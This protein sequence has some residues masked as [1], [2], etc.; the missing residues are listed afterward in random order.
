[1][2]V[3]PVP[4][5]DS[6]RAPETAR[7]GPRPLARSTGT[8]LWAQLRADLLRRLEGGEFREVFPGE[9]DLVAEYRVSRHTVREALRQLRAQGLVTAQ[10]GRPSRLTAARPLEQKVGEPYS[11]F[12]SVEEVGAVQRSVVHALDQRADGVVAARLGLEESTPLVYLER[13]RLADE[14]PLAVDRVWLPAAVARPLLDVDLTRT[15]LY[16]ELERHCA[17]RVRSGWERIRAVVPGRGERILLHCPESIALFAI[18]RLGHDADRRPVE[19]RQTLV[20]ADRFAVSAAFSADDG[21]RLGTPAR[22]L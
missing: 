13:L 22:T 8:P 17:T 20:R 6:G 19:W 2:S 18:D 12:R 21:Y 7:P 15:S 4:L 16:E 10:R 1:M 3:S 11:L 5:P 14:E 9:H